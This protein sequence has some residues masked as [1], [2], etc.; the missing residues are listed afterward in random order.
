VPD[1]ERGERAV[2][3]VEL[4]SRPPTSDWPGRLLAWAQSAGWPVDEVRPVRRI[5]LDRR[6]GSRIDYRRLR[7]ALA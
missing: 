1:G 3:A 5:P 6:H 2:L 4:A 7:M